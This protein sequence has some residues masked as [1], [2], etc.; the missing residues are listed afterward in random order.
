MSDDIVD[1]FLKDQKQIPALVYVQ[2][3]IFQFNKGSKDLYIFI[4]Q[5]PGGEVEHSGHYF[6]KRI[7]LRVYIPYYLPQTVRNSLTFFLDFFQ[8]VSLSGYCTFMLVS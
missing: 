7:V 2:F 8:Q 4:F 6:F 3:Y 1:G 5:D